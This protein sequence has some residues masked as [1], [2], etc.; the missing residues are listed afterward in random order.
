MLHD[1]ANGCM[2][3]LGHGGAIFV[4]GGR[5]GHTI[6]RMDGLKSIYEGSATF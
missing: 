3:G 6:F 4:V 5:A 1:T 2:L